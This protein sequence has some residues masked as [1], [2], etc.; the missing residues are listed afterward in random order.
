MLSTRTCASS[1][2]PLLSCFTLSS[3]LAY[4]SALARK[5]SAL[6]GSCCIFCCVWI[7]FFFF[8]FFS[9]S[10]LRIVIDFLTIIVWVLNYLNS[11][12]F[13]LFLKKFIFI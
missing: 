5:L 10:L 3:S 6:S 9:N 7:F 8:F 2:N 13:F 12:I 11:I 4:T 1:C